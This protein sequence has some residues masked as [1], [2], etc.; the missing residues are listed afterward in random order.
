MNKTPCNF[1]VSFS[2]CKSQAQ[3]QEHDFS[4][5]AVSL[6][7]KFFGLEVVFCF[8]MEYSST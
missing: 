1:L 2:Y 7:R 6:K 8:L 5:I 3:L 4:S